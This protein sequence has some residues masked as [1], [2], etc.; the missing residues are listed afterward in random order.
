MMHV[1]LYGCHK[2]EVEPAFQ[3]MVAAIAFWKVKNN[4]E[5]LE[6][7]EV[8]NSS[9]VSLFKCLP[10]PMSDDKDWPVIVSCS[11][12]SLY[13][14]GTLALLARACNVNMAFVMAH[15]SP[16]QQTELQSV[17]HA[18]GFASLCEEIG[19]TVDTYNRYAVLL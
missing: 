18:H 11:R 10:L 15:I 1:V 13:V 12:A 3:L 9:W 5:L 17:A 16:L 14:T 19:S 6:A 4:C 2:V 8:H 7:S